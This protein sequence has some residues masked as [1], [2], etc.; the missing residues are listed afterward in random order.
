MGPERTKTELLPHIYDL[1]EGDADIKMA[2]AES[3]VSLKDC[4]YLGGFA[5]VIE[6]LKV[7]E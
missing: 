2:L 1:V 3:I 7:L 5:H 4:M 6:L